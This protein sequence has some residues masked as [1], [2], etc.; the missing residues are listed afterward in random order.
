MAKTA[1]ISSPPIDIGVFAYEGCSAWITAGLLELFAIANTAIHSVSTRGEAPIGFRFHAISRT[2]RSVRGSHGVRFSV[3][4]LRRRY[5]AII[6]PPLWGN[7]RREVIDRLGRLGRECQ[8]LQQLAR[9]ASI[10]A[11]TCTGTALLAKAGLLEGHR[12]TTCWWMIDW[13]R[14]EFPNVVLTGDKLVVTDSDRW[15]AGAGA[16][17]LHLGLGL[18]GH[19]CG[20]QALSATARLMLIERRRGSQSPFI[21]AG[22]ADRDIADAD[23]ARMAR[24]LERNAGA[25]LTIGEVC[26]QMNLN[27]RSMTRKFQGSLGVSP[28]VYL[29]SLRVARAKRLLEQTTSS[30][31]EVVTKCGYEDVSSFRKL[32]SRQVGMT[33]REFRTR[34]GTAKGRSS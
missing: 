2:S 4:S 10:M 3:D 33:P 27:V 7:S 16:A 30:F 17:Y 18:V 34:F 24:F 26:R 29:Q 1:S 20:E 21:E 19:F 22:L 32:F 25:A 31:E 23:V 6:V 5:E 13:F 28:L 15:T 8:M 14:R 12:A 11:G 9:R